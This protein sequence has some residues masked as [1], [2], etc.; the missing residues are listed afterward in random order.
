MRYVRLPEFLADW[1]RLTPRERGLVVEWLRTV[2]LPAVEAYQKNPAGYVWPKALRFERLAGAG[3]VCAVTWSF[4]GP[5]GWATFH[6]DT[7][8]NEPCLVWR[9]VGHHDIYRHP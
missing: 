9:R 5:D 4:A 1:E 8:D 3:G 7:S 2:F 6:F